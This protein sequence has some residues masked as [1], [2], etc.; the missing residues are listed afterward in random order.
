M[1]FLPTRPPQ[2]IQEKCPLNRVEALMP[3]ARREG[4][5]KV[6][7]PPPFS[8]TSSRACLLFV[9]PASF[10]ASSPICTTLELVAGDKKLEVEEYE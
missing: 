2:G 7:H 1:E 10:N 4:G 3:G 5:A 8:S 9:H 6:D